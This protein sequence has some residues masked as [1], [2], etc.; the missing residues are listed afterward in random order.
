M[1]NNTNVVINQNQLSDRL[2][3]A[4][5][6]K[7]RAEIIQDL[8]D[9]KLSEE[10]IQHY[11]YQW[12]DKTLLKDY[13]LK[14][15]LDSEHLD[16]A[17]F[18]KILHISKNEEWLKQ[19][20]YDEDDKPEWMNLIDEAFQL[21]RNNLVKDFDHLQLGYAFRPFLL[22]A[23]TK[24][25]EYY[26][27]TPTLA[28]KVDWKHLVPS[29]MY[30]LASG[31]MQIGARAFVL[32]LH[33]A[34]QMNELHGDTS[35]ERFESFIKEKILDPDF[36]EFAY[37][38]YPVLARLLMIRTKFL[39]DNSIEALNRFDQ[40]WNKMNQEFDLQNELL[41]NISADMGDSHQ[42]GQSVMKFIFSSEKEIL[43]K[44][45]SISIAQ[46]FNQLLEWFNQKGFQP[47]LKG[48]KI[49]DHV[50]YTWEE[51]VEYKS[52]YSTEEIQRY[53][54]RLGGLLGILYCV[55]GADFHSE[56]IIANGE[57]PTFIDLET[58]FHHTPK[59]S[60]EPTADMVANE[61]IVNSV[62]GTALLPH[63]SFKNPDGKGI[64]M[65][66]MSSTDQEL[67]MPILQVE[68]DGT[69]E[70]RYVRKPVEA[71]EADQNVPKINDVVVHAADYVDEILQ[72][73][74][75]ICGIIL[76][77]KK[78]L[79]DEEGVIASFKKDTIRVILRPTQYYGNFIIESS[80]PDYLR[81]WIERD[82]LLE[83][84]WFTNL[85]IRPISFEKKDLLDHDI[86]M[87]YT[88]PGS[89]DLFSSTGENIPDFYEQSSYEI[90]INRINELSSQ[91]IIEQSN[92]IKASI[93][94]NSPE[95][96]YEIK[97]SKTI[98]EQEEINT[99]LF[100]EEAEKIGNQLLEQAI[101]GKFNDAT[102]IGLETNYHNQWQVSALERG[103]YNGLGGIVLFLSYLNKVTQKK[104]YKELADKAL[105]SIIG[106]P[107]FNRDFSSAFF[108]Q[109]SDI[110]VFSHIARLYGDN[111]RIRTSIHKKMENIQNNVTNDQ[112]FD[113][114]GGS[115]G[116][117]QVLLNVYEQ[118]DSEQALEIAQT[119]GDH[120]IKNKV[121]MDHGVGWTP[122][123]SQVP[124]GGLSHG[125]S[126]IA[127]SLLRLYKLTNKEKYAETALEA[128][129]YDRSLYHP[130]E[131]N[132][133]DCRT[134]DTKAGDFSVSWCHGAAGVGLSRLLYL[135]YINDP[136]LKKEIETA[137]S[138][139]A[140]KG[141]GRSH[142]LCH[143]DLGNS[144]LFLMAGLELEQPD[145]IHF[146][147]SVGMNVIQEKQKRGNYLTGVAHHIE[148][149]G[150]FLGL[151]GIGYQLLRLA[152]PDVVPSI[153]TLEKGK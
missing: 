65:S 57:Y 134:A 132:W 53:Y 46:H 80:H 126:G 106:V 141:F 5:S 3:K 114:L 45:K 118:F 77:H 104:E 138:T 14:D 13:A 25:E 152:K 136:L 11:L 91:H 62:L 38:E 2:Y 27:S 21:N 108:G 30:N 6:I 41:C 48:Y 68:N 40:D 120:L 34:K 137:L 133:A 16:E 1:M 143:G 123:S 49:I 44:P 107:I 110:Y 52:C 115:A 147:Q 54:T 18:A 112:Y 109:A 148:L 58:L 83:R 144:E 60:T 96:N 101:Y 42:K 67:P 124:L 99:D 116:I 76:N 78:E 10:E 66:G 15:R 81:D 31:L 122:D 97:S 142:S 37:S 113:L 73:F 85:D 128:I 4:L 125:T 130:S 145:H 79:M 103:L 69:D 131:E 149:P 90:V 26:R 129:T 23:N 102:W 9:I 146:A 29:L 8:E 22:W 86:P 43:Y 119:Y 55:N 151:S 74:Q 61:K 47:T 56:N 36:L 70:M 153:L 89:K 24:F 72:G 64:D 95:Q 150:L 39:V 35:V 105:E 51:K 20:K 100:I 88:Y 71:K 50:S 92:W 93:V 87:F 82:Q 127:W 84:V 33:I 59:L 12:R 98:L 32:E 111:D 139:T 63:L 121:A 117:I 28:N 75:K 7:E 140:A 19:Y 135:P 94:S 17:T